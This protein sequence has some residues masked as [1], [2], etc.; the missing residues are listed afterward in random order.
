MDGRHAQF[1]HACTNERNR[2]STI[3]YDRGE[4]R[5]GES[6]V[7]EERIKEIKGKEMRIGR[8]VGRY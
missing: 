2:R 6:G 4:A 5:R 8:L 3:K 7:R 1:H